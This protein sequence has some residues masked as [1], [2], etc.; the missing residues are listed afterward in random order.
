MGGV[1]IVRG[2]IVSGDTNKKKLIGECGSGGGD[3]LSMTCPIEDKVPVFVDKESC[4][5]ALFDLHEQAASAGRV[6]V[7]IE[8]DTLARAVSS[9]PYWCA[10]VGSV[11]YENTVC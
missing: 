9:I 3:H 6:S 10:I 8:H 7:G 5:Q 11:R 2:W 4:V 1:V